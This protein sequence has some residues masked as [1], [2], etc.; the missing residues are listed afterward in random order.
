M[1]RLFGEK[2]RFLR[3]Q[4]GITQVDLAHRLSLASYARIIRLEAN[5]DAPSL[6]LVRR[7][8]RLFNVTTD[9]M[10]RDTIPVDAVAASDV[11]QVD[12]SGTLPQLFGAKLRARRLSRKLSQTDVARNLRLGSRAYISNLELGR[13]TPSLDLV[14]QIADLFGV[15]TEYLLCDA[16]PV[17]LEASSGEDARDTGK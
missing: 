17:E 8:S 12:D 4:S 2:L 1:P 15:T 11:E 14:V 16:I 6:A 5:Q 13:K 9:Y 10:L 3:H 7:I